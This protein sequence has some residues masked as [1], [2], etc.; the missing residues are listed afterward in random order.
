[1][2]MSPGNTATPVGT[3]D[4]RLGLAPGAGAFVVDAGRG[5][6]G[7]GQPVE[8]H[9]GEQLV[10]VDGVLGQAGARVGPFLELLDDPGEL[11]D[12]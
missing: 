3:G 6:G 7:A 10:A 12:R 5:A 9:V 2:V 4:R 11:A 8:H 1:M